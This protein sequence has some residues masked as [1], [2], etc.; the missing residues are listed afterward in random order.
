MVFFKYRNLIHQLDHQAFDRL[1]QPGD[2]TLYSGIYRCEVCGYEI[3]ST[4][5]D[6]MPPEHHHKHTLA[7][8]P[9]SWRLIV[10]TIQKNPDVARDRESRNR[11]YLER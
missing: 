2:T 3:V 7:Q 4:K 10:R 1:L 9:I 6:S 8:G 5:G 11:G